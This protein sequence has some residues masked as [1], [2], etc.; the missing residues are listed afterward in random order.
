[1]HGDTSAISSGGFAGFIKG[2]WDPSDVSYAR[3]LER[4]TPV[5]RW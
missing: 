2:R 3:P 1:M 4:D 5:D